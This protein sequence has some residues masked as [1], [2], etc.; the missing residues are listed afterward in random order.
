MRRMLVRWL[1]NTLALFVAVQFVHGILFQGPWWSLVLVAL[2]FGLV[3]ALIKPIVK[4]LSCPLI[5]VTL[6]LFT[7]V[8]N[9][10]MLGLTSWLS[11]RF[12]LRFEVHG[13]WAA[14]WGALVVSVVSFLLTMLIGKWKDR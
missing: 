13:F 2:V 1:I 4:L 12:G 6:G 3:N 7:L 11:T 10:V 5:I 14:F 8:I 9:A